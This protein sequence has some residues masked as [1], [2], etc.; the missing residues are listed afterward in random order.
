MLNFGLIAAGAAGSL[1]VIWVVR[2]LFHGKILTPGQSL[3][4]HD[5]ADFS[6]SSS[7]TNW[8]KDQYCLDCSASLSWDEYFSNKCCNK[9]GAARGGLGLLGGERLWRKIVHNGKWKTQYRYG[10]KFEIV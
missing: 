3:P 8:S 10:D 9:C 7:T 4:D 5:P 2:S 6:S 1:A